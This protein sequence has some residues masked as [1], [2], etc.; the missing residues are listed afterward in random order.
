MLC[1]RFLIGITRILQTPIRFISNRI[2]IFIFSI[3]FIRKGTIRSL[4]NWDSSEIF[5]FGTPLLFPMI[6]H[7]PALKYLTF[8]IRLMPSLPADTCMASAKKAF[9]YLCLASPE[10]CMRTMSPSLMLS[11]LVNLFMSKVRMILGK[12]SDL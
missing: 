6:L 5:G 7:D 8:A 3:R 11:L 10:R 1:I 2:R 4:M 12:I 9:S